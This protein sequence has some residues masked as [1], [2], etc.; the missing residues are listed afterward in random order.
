MVSGI[1][2]IE[3]LCFGTDIVSVPSIGR[4][5]DTIHAYPLLVAILLYNG[6]IIHVMSN[7]SVDIPHS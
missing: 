7:Y 1:E 6:V 5:L 4:A 3:S 2:S